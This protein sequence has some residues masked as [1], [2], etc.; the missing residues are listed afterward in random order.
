MCGIGLCIFGTSSAFAQ[1]YL[2]YTILIAFA[3]FF[4]YS[5]FPVLFILGECSLPSQ[6]QLSDTI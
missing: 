6:F 1:S 4:A 5:I 3:G 2:A